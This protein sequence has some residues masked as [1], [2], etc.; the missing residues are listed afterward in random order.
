VIVLAAGLGRRFDA[1]SH[2]LEQMLGSATVLS[3]SLTRVMSSGL[4]LIVVTTE[5][6]AESVQALVARRDMVVVA[7]DAP[8]SGMG[9]SIAAGVQA[10]PQA[11]GWLVMPADMPLVRATTL[12]AVA[13]AIREHPIA[14]AQHQGRKGHPVGFSAELYSELSRLTGDEGARRVVARYPAMP[15]EVDDPGVLL[16]IDT[17]DD[18]LVARAYQEAGARA[19]RATK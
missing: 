14:F 10:R 16:D 7:G 2:K 4:P 8:G 12:Q 17:T 18:L 9:L 5:R 15:V 13:R 6:L 11:E 3:S 19:D 1:T